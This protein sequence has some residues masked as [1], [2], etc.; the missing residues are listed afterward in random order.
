[1]GK[2]FAG[3]LVPHLVPDDLRPLNLEIISFEMAFDLNCT[4]TME[5]SEQR[6]SLLPRP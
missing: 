6:S 1:M 5:N 2:A 4:L 3:P